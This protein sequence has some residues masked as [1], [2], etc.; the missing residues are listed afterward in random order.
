MPS[1]LANAELVNDVPALGLIGAGIIS[2]VAMAIV[3]GNQASSLAPEF[4]THVSASGLLEDFRSESA[5]W[6]LPI[7]SLAFTLMNLVIAW[8]T[9]PIDRFASRFA[10]AAALTV[11][12]IAWVAVIRIL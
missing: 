10:L 6:R 5:L 7:I 11:Q 8:F 4:A 12:L 3:V 9:A 2:L 1:V